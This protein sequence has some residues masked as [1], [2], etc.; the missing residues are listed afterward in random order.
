MIT[1]SYP[2]FFFFFFLHVCPDNDSHYTNVNVH[3]S[4]KNND[5]PITTK[6]SVSS[7]LKRGKYSFD[8]LFSPA[9]SMVK[10]MTTFVNGNTTLHSHHQSGAWIKTGSDEKHLTISL[11]AFV[12]KDPRQSVPLAGFIGFVFTCM[13]G[14]LR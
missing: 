10:K 8:Y 6:Y 2:F 14:E 7:H 1:M 3:S 9:F 11:S 5:N 13:P 12:C 4:C